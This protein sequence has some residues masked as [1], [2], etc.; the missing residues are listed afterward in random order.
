M[1]AADGP[2]TSPTLPPSHKT[3]TVG[4]SRMS[5]MARLAAATVASAVRAV[6]ATVN[7]PP[8]PRAVLTCNAT[9]AGRVIGPHGST[10]KRLQQE[11]STS[12]SV[13]SKRDPCE[14]VIRHLRRGS[15]R[16][17]PCNLCVCVCV[18]VCECIFSLSRSRALSFPPPSLSVSLPLS[19]PHAPSLSP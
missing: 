5:R 1:V 8:K 3:T 17:G 13:D 2:M 6:N 11:S 19:W 4:G 18:C 9:V 7:P 12:I 10:I 14:I 16:G 15:R